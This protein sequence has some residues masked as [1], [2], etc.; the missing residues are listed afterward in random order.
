MKDEESSEQDT[1]DTDKELL[2][3]CSRVTKTINRN[4]H[5]RVVEPKISVKVRPRNGKYYITA[6]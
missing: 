2:D 6:N 5:S 1:D 4:L 3:S